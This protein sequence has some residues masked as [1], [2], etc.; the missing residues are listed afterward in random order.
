MRFLLVLILFFPM[1]AFS[2]DFNNGCGSGWNEPIVPDHVRSLCINFS[3]ACANHDNCYS[4]CLA[5]GENYGKE[6]CTQMAE[7]QRN[8]RKTICDNT[9]LNEMKKTCDSCDIARRP[10]C[11]GVASLY[12]IAVKKGGHGSFNGIVASNGYYNFISSPSA[13][14]FDFSQFVEDIN[15]IQNIKGISENND[16][17]IDIE[18]SSPVAK[19]VSIE[20]TEEITPEKINGLT[21]IDSLKYGKVDLGSASNGNQPITLKNIDL[22]KI[23]L[24]K[25]KNEQRFTK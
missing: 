12:K 1:I 9:F 2:E 19:F 14:T 20:K 18:E 5:G 21:S 13:E 25:L 23:D 22:D 8:G 17:T 7:D 4:K 6:I 15:D 3:S 11:N 16:I 24:G 10:I